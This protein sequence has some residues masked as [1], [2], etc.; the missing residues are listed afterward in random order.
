MLHPLVFISIK[1]DSVVY[2]SVI[3]CDPPVWMLCV[4]S[5][6]E[7]AHASGCDPGGSRGDEVPHSYATHQRTTEGKGHRGSLQG[8]G[9]HAAQVGKNTCRYHTIRETERST[10]ISGVCFPLFRD[11]PFSIIYF[12][13]FANLN[14]LGKKNAD[15]PAPF[16]VS[17]V[18]GCVAGSTAAVAVNPVDGTFL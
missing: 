12:P 11:V 9:S 18:S 14:N 17:F 16:Y 15:G 4:C 5:G 8:P 2:V 10:A 3:Q 7:E 6:S 1:F 13:L